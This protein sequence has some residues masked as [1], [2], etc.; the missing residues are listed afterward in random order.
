MLDAQELSVR[1]FKIE[2]EIN[3]LF[4]VCVRAVTTF[5]SLDLS[6]LVGHS[7]ELTLVVNE[8]RRWQGVCTSAEFVRASETR[9]GLATYDLILRPTL[10][11]LTQRRGNRLFQHATIPEIV[12]RILRE[13]GIEHQWQVAPDSYPS[14]EH[15]TQ[16]DESDFAFVSRLLGPNP[17]FGRRA[18]I[19]S[20]AS[21][22]PHSV[23]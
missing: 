19:Q 13:W 4:T 1:T 8:A 22:H 7:A 15:R 17:H 14:L 20:G 21:R 3:G 11:R 9:E 10:W 5:E 12:T 23:R 16:F 18:T 6:A 2:E